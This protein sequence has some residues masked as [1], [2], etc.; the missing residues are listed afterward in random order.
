MADEVKFSEIAERVP[1]EKPVGNGLLPT[2]C[3]V[4]R[5]SNGCAC[6]R[7]FGWLE[8]CLLL[9]SIS[10]V[11][12]LWPDA[13]RMW[14]EWTRP[15]RQTPARAEL[16]LPSGFQ[17]EVQY[18]LY[19]P[20]NYSPDKAWPLLIFLH[21]SGERGDD[22][23]MVRRSGPPALLA[24]GKSL[25]MIVVSP[26]CRADCYWDNEQLL[27]LLDHLEKQFSIES[28]R[29][30]LGGHSMGAYG[31]WALAAAAPDRFAAIVPVAVGG[32][33]NDVPKLL[34]LAVWAFHG[35][36]DQVVPLADSKQMVDAI[37][38]AGGNARLTIYPDRGHDTC[39]VTFSN[40]EVDDWL[41]RQRR[42][43]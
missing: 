41:L 6:R 4:A 37:Q 30:Y 14:R 34:K 7:R 17:T 11:A 5:A 19:L 3:K 35:A 22:L 36:K 8:I 29:V 26:Q 1:V 16:K 9:S 28:D 10:L 42:A 15:G 25:P 43:K 31:T 33:T 27:A 20:V 32:N 38:A 2:D 24:K 13:A 21:G 23:E 40:N 18:F 12:Q 39:N